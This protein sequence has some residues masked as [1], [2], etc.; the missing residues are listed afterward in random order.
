MD[1]E[2]VTL[3]LP[4]PIYQRARHAAEALQKP[5]EEILVNT[6]ASNLPVLDDVPTEMA[7]ELTAMTYLSDEALWEL[8]NS[9]MAV[10]RQERLTWLLDSQGR[11]EL[12]ETG[13][14][15]LAGLM[16]EYGRHM[17]RRSQAVAL[18]TAR[19]YPVPADLS[20]PTRQ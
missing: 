16:A 15:E 12:D 18:L 10:E 6:L 4:E 17:L 13:E 8:A 2:V 7:G 14:R 19:G 3:N 1:V 5:L 20:N 9:T 11:G